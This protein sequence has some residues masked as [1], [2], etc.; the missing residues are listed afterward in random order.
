MKQPPASFFAVLLLA[1]S[2]C[3]GGGPARAQTLERLAAVRTNSA[4]PT[5]TASGARPRRLAP[6][7]VGATPEGSRVTVASD[8]PLD[9]YAAYRK[10]DN[11]YVLVP[12]AE[13][14]GPPDGL[15]GRGFTGA[16]LDARGGDVLL[17]FRL[18]P[19]AEAR[20]AQKFNRLDV[21]FVA[22]AAQGGAT[23]QASASQEAPQ[24]ASGA[25][26]ADDH[27]LV[28]QLLRRIEQL[29]GQV[30]EL[31]AGAS[32]APPPPTG[33]PPPAVSAQAEAPAATAAE[34]EQAQAMPGEHEH[35]AGAGP[36]LRIQGFGDVNFRASNERGSTSRFGVGQLDLFITSKL[37]EKFSVLSELVLEAKR[38]NSFEF[39]IHRLLLRYAPN[40]YVNLSAGRYHS[41]IGFYNTTFHHG[42]WFAT[43]ADRPFLFAFE[44]AGG[45][46]P[47]HNVGVSA[48]GRIPSGGLG[49][50]YVAEVGNGRAA[51]S[52][53]NRT[54][55][56]ATDE[57]NGKSFNLGLS[58]RP[59]RAPGLQTGFSFYHDRL[60]PA[61]LP[62]IDQSIMAGY[63]VYQSP[64]YEFLNEALFIRHSPGG[65]RVAYT[66][67]FYTQVARR[68]GKTTPFF[69]D[70]YV[71]A[72]GRDLLFASIGRRNGA[73]AGVR[74]DV[75]DYA[76]LKAQYERTTR[77]GL[78]ALDELILQLAFT[79]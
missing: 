60:T 44:G 57:N 46:L 62:V 54:V 52:P 12:R 8:A 4:P 6:L 27:E 71:N 48:T 40:D 16:R 42:S 2:L 41:A 63:V 75:S 55:Q 36:R 51:R 1:Q 70:Q 39:E 5:A 79:F 33:A 78:T 73:A 28:L 56:T 65:G 72:P 66:P 47:L 35:E 76:A 38:D 32:A 34:E 7:R 50:R 29:E 23:A 43:A 24:R 31:R 45:P 20:V 18:E 64:K 21:T 19:G 61:A 26:S 13:A 22:R 30:R 69:R 59:D 3:L 67:G 37:S 9:G 53:A 10:G 77:R 14:S 49:L 17:S 74:Y 25:A 58:A 68:F 15:A 11:F